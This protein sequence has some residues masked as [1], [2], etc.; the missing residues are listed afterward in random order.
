MPTELLNE[1]EVPAC[2]ELLWEIF[3][4]LNNSRTFGLG[5]NPIT[6]SDIQAYCSLTN[7]TLEPYQVELLVE[8]DYAFLSV[9]IDHKTDG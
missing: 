1:P 8:M 3:T 4:K 7:T 2:G 6:Y 5:E 9:K